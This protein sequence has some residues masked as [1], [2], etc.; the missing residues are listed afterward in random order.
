MAGRLVENN[1]NRK[2]STF[3][4]QMFDHRRQKRA[5]QLLPY[6]YIFGR[7]RRA[8]LGLRSQLL[9]MDFQLK[10]WFLHEISVKNGD[11]SWKFS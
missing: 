6:R 7:H 4:R 5:R 10:L 8:G 11:F 2:S 9:K 1:G 3:C